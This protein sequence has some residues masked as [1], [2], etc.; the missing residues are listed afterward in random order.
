M[1]SGS[2]WPE[3][4]SRARSITGTGDGAV[5]EPLPSRPD[6]RF[7]LAACSAGV[8]KSPG[9]SAEFRDF[10]LASSLLA[11]LWL[12]IT[13]GWETHAVPMPAPLCPKET[14]YAEQTYNSAFALPERGSH[15]R[16]HY[17]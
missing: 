17:Y 12:L 14:S 15:R 11:C 4:Y 8:I 7:P 1:P 9:P 6:R 2:V 13:R 3:H 10:L 16:H 5:G